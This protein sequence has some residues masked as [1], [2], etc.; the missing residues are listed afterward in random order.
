MHISSLTSTRRLCSS[1]AYIFARIKQVLRRLHRS[2]FQCFRVMFMNKSTSY[3]FT[4]IAKARKPAETPSK[5][6]STRGSA[7]RVCSGNVT[8]RGFLGQSCQTASM[9]VFC[10]AAR[11]NFRLDSFEYRVLF[12]KTRPLFVMPLMSIN[13]L[14]VAKYV[15]AARWHL[16]DISYSYCHY[17][18]PYTATS[19]LDA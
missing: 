9:A 14:R 19:S 4:P 8:A 17:R 6:M 10:A 2:Y 11:P 12:E 7:S 3:N 1:A 16:I 5:V 15:K 18:T 13:P